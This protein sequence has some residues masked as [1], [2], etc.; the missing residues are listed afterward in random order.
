VWKLGDL[1]HQAL[2][3]AAEGEIYPPSGTEEIGNEGEISALYSGEEQRW[4]PSIDNPAVY[5]SNLQVRID[6]ARDFNQFVLPAQ[7]LYE[8]RY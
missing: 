3:S 1:L 6:L 7:Y 5:L 8:L 4:T 2:G